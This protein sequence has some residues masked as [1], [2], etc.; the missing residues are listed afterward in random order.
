LVVTKD[1]D[2]LFQSAVLNFISDAFHELWTLSD[3]I[4]DRKVVEKKDT[5]SDIVVHTLSF[6]YPKVYKRF[7]IVILPVQC[8]ILKIFYPNTD[9]G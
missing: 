5:D 2:L 1:E 6:Y 7:L 8:K 9:M 4:D 3:N